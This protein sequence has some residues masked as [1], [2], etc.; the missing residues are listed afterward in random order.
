MK[1]TTP[2]ACL[3]FLGPIVHVYLL[4][5]CLFDAK[6][7]KRSNSVAVI[8]TV[9]LCKAGITD[10][11]ITIHKLTNRSHYQQWLSCKGEEHMRVS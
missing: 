6:N 4:L 2:K 3:G 8:G 11:A 10:Q 9:P 7:N 5:D 1:S